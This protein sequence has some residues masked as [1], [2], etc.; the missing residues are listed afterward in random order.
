MPQYLLH[1]KHPLRTAIYIILAL[2]L[3][4]GGIITFKASQTSTEGRSK[5]AEDW[6][7]GTNYD[8]GFGADSWVGWDGLKENPLIVNP[9]PVAGDRIFRTKGEGIIVLKGRSG[10]AEARIFIDN[11]V[12]VF[13]KGQKQIKIRMAITPKGDNKIDNCCRFQLYAYTGDRAL[14]NTNTKLVND[15]PFSAKAD[16]LMHVYT[17]KVPTIGEIPMSKAVLVLRE[18]GKEKGFGEGDILTVDYIHF[19]YIPV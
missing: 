14:T 3:V 12:Y 11:Q 8:F 2:G 7:Q 1:P 18:L 6:K 9:T 13:P 16:G 17:I 19:E 15:L 4:V 5:A 10:K